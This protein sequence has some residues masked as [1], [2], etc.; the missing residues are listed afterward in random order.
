MHTNTNLGKPMWSHNVEQKTI[1]ETW[2]NESSLPQPTQ[3]TLK[4]DSERHIINLEKKLQALREPGRQF[5]YR[6]G[7]MAREVY[8]A[9]IDEDNESQSSIVEGAK[10]DEENEGLWLL[11]REQRG[12]AD[13]C[14]D[15]YDSFDELHN[16]V[17]KTENMYTRSWR[18]WLC[19]YGYE[20]S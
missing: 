1:N 14:S 8:H 10:V 6:A 20:E 4:T 3:W 17:K 18:D 19:C 7:W 5:E 9:P 15:D 13:N 2:F 12:I 11:W 16:A